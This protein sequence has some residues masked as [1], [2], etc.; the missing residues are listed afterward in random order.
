[1]AHAAND[2]APD[3]ARALSSSPRRGHVRVAEAIKPAGSQLLVDHL[4]DRHPRLVI[5]RGGDIAQRAQG[6]LLGLGEEPHRGQ[7]TEAALH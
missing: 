7:V 5:L 3:R 2:A 6:R 4:G 1:V